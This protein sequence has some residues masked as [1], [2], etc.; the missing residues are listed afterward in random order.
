MTR[1]RSRVVPAAILILALAA[2]VVGQRRAKRPV[3]AQPEPA[4]VAAAAPAVQA[5]RK[6]PFSAGETFAYDI[7][8]SSYLTAGVATLSVRDKRPVGATQAYY[9]VGE[10]KPVGLVSKLYTVYYKA[11]TLLDSR[12]LLP[13]RG[14][15]FSQEGGR[16]RNRITRFDHAALRADYQVET[17]TDVRNSLPLPRYTQDALSSI[18]AL[19][20]VPLEENSRLT[21]PVCDGGQVYRVQFVIGRVE[22]VPTGSGTIR[23]FHIT[24]TIADAKGRPVGRPMTLWLSADARQAPV[25]L[26]AELAIGSVNLTLR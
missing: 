16:Q 19:R 21:M 10:A 20:A 6:V 18:Y 25:R 2:P 17:T 1:D 26:Q 5:D 11:D 15:L 23:A 3:V 14:S 8:W 4:R 22:P 24:P 9:I 7:S 13:R 12:T